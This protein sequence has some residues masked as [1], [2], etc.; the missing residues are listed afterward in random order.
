[1]QPQA[2]EQSQQ[3]SPVSAI[4]SSVNENLMKLMDVF[5]QAQ[6]PPQDIQKLGT[7]LSSFQSLVE[8]LSGNAQSEQDQEEMPMMGQLPANASPDSKPLPQG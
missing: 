6:L 4:I 8:D 5:N 3:E 2:P 1:M 7:I